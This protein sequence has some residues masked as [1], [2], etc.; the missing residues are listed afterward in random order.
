MLSDGGGS[1]FVFVQNKT[2]SREGSGFAWVERV[3]RLEL[4]T[5][6]PHL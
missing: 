6:T 5:V 2:T 3:T 4:A 1:E